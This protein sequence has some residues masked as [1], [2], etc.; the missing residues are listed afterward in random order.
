MEGDGV[1]VVVDVELGDEAAVIG[2]GPT[3]NVAESA[4]GAGAVNVWSVGVSQRTAPFM[5][6]Q[7]CQ[8]LVV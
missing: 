7:Q 5:R 2:V 4:D 1:V 8:R 3:E 6:P